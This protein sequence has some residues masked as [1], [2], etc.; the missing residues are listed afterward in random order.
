MQLH[1]GDRSLRP[2]GLGAHAALG[3]ALLALLA[4]PAAGDPPP[5]L[6]DT[7]LY[8]DFASRTLAP[9]V[10]PF[11]PQYPLWSDG[12]SKRRW[13]RLPEGSAI[14]AS[15]PDAWVFPI[16]T[17]IWK[18]FSLERRIETRYMERTASGEWLYATYRWN[19]GGTAAPLAPARGVK[20]AAES[21]PGVP[22]GLP[23]VTDCRACHESGASAV[24]GFSAL[25]LSSDRDP[26]AP[27]AMAPEPGSLDLEELVRRGLVVGLPAPLA[28]HAPVVGAASP[29]AR[30]ALGY[31]HGNCSHCHNARSPVA[32]LG[33]SFTV[34]AD[35]TPEALATAVGAESLYRPTGSSLH[36]RVVP[37]APAES[38]LIARASSRQPPL[39]MPPLATRLIDEEALAL[40]ERWIAEDLE[41]SPATADDALATALA[42]ASEI[43]QENDR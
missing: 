2:G 1:H 8:A 20:L 42:P 43:P 24:L 29:V 41:P 10:E 12:A 14:D 9:G 15:D 26:G 28:A 40:L 18:E 25:Q 4:V 38:L 31:L 32:S 17:R 33:L 19:E 30:A 21:R 16:G 23:S 37:G 22:Y 3:S 27:H 39:Q 5:T 6:A 34:R 11:S 36:V 7:G 35:G 13:I